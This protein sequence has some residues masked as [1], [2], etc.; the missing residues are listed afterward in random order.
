MIKHG[1]IGLRRE[2]EDIEE[3]K[4]IYNKTNMR[5]WGKEFWEGL[6]PK[7]RKQWEELISLL[8]SGQT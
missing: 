1:F 8:K 3:F 6:S 2:K 4:A 7:A 5:K